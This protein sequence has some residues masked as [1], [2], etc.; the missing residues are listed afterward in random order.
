MC[1][2][3][4]Y[5]IIVIHDS[6]TFHEEKI[7]I[8]Q[9]KKQCRQSGLKLTPQR[10][11]VFEAL[12]S[13]YSHPSSEAIYSR[14]HKKF[15]TISKATVYKTLDTFEKHGIVS[16]V[17]SLHDKKRYDPLTARHHHIICTKCSKIFDL[18]DPELDKLK[19]PKQ[20][21][22]VGKLVDFSV[23]FSV[24]CLDCQY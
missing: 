6:T 5:V 10:I 19:I 4:Y 18:I 15:P 23:H 24:I 16:A 1:N 7:I 11:A 21:T 9:F 20:V 12:M 3:D 13:D 17:T 8:E 2:H 14:V 22:K